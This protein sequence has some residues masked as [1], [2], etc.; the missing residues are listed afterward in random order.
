MTAAPLEQRDPSSVLPAESADLPEILE[1]RDA[2]VL[3]PYAG[4]DHGSVNRR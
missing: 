3:K 4:A 2:V 1:G